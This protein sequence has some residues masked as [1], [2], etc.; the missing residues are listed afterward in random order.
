MDKAENKWWR[1]FDLPSGSMQ[2]LQIGPTRIQ[3]AHLERE[4]RVAASRVEEST[5]PA[6]LD[7]LMVSPPV[8][9]LASGLSNPS[10][11]VEVSRY[12]TRRTAAGFRLVPLMADRA[13]V[14]R[15]M[16]PLFVMPG[17]QVEMFMSSPVWVSVFL[18][19]LSATDG[20][21]VADIPAAQLADTWIGEDTI[22]GELGYFAL[23][24]ARLS[25]KDVKVRPHMATTGVVVRNMS[26]R[27]LR[28]E[29]M[30]L[31]A[32][33]LHV[34]ATGDGALC[35]E[36]IILE[37]KEGGSFAELEIMSQ[38]LGPDVPCTRVGHAR[39]DPKDNA[40]SKPFASFNLK[41]LIA[42]KESAP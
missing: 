3:I 8:P 16:N 2:N 20:S 24:R 35:T 40:G 33:W 37:H 31:P 7:R 13:V 34:Y 22:H 28:I 5:D 4:W 1:N 18:N 15:P 41:N 12:A 36:G 14:C 38:P 23:T 29:H 17:D 26:T 39:K 21:H 32:P 42:R 10:H 27:P 6:E 30:S 9:V 25:Y 11:D 19:S